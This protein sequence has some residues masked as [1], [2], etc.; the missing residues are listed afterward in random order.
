MFLSFFISFKE[1]LEAALII[2][3]FIGILKRF[4]YDNEIKIIK[5]AVLLALSITVFALLIISFLGHSIPLFSTPH[6]EEIFEGSSMILSVIFITWAIF[7][8]HGHL[9]HQSGKH[10]TALHEKIKNNNFDGFF[11]LVFILLAREG[12]EIVLFSSSLFLSE[13]S[14]NILLS[15]LSGMAVAGL[16]GVFTYATAVSLKKIFQVAS[17]FLIITSGGL[18]MQG[19]GELTEAG[20]IPEMNFLAL[21][22]PFLDTH[23]LFTDIIFKSLLGFSG[24]LSLWQYASYIFYIFITFAILRRLDQK[25]A[26]SYVPKN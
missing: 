24:N 10:F 2:G 20:I 18:L 21:R 17:V 11:W 14:A 13:R 3:T 26:P 6:L 15:S 19:I 22:L 23:N 1:S 12:L 8:L 4:S 9:K 16:L 25:A 7:W 5:R